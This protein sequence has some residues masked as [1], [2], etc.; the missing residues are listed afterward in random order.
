MVGLSM[1]TFGK[2]DGR[3]SMPAWRIVFIVDVQPEDRMSGFDPRRCDGIVRHGHGR[4]R[5]S[6]SA[7][8]TDF[9]RARFHV[10]TEYGTP[11]SL[12]RQDGLATR[13]AANCVW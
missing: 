1:A 12:K 6:R 4:R 7:V 9:S 13:R 11:V 3:R 2:G 8:M 5:W 10:H